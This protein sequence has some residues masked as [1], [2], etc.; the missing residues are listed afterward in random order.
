MI[1]KVG[2]FLKPVLNYKGFK[3][4]IQFSKEDNVYYG[5]IINITDFVGFDGVTVRDAIKSFKESVEDYISFCKEM[6]K[7]IKYKERGI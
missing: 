4:I 5:T 7:E 3:T 1:K 6:G 2:V